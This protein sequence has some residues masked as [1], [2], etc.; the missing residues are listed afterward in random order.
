[1]PRSNPPSENTTYEVGRTLPSPR[2]IYIVGAQSTGKTTL[3]HALERFF[4]QLTSDT[5]TLSPPRIV[6]EVARKVLREIDFKTSDIRDSP[7]LSYELQKLILQKQYEAESGF[8][9]GWMISDRSAVDP[10]MYAKQHVGEAAVQELLDTREWK[11]LEQNMRA[12][13]VV[14][15][16][17]GTDWLKDDGVRL[18]PESRE[19]WMDFHIKFC[20]FMVERGIPF[21]VLPNTMTKLENRV[22]FVAKLWQGLG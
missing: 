9:N 5:E 17:A 15:C 7:T 8:D 1:M 16:E 2:N 22:E 10:V 19:D 14:V 18:M 12:S 21:V 6:T 11:V 13:L 3:V 4:N 20:N